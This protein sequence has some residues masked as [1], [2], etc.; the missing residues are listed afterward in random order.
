M[1]IEKQ[2]KLS[3]RGWVQLLP[4]EPKKVIRSA[5]FIMSVFILSIYC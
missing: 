4:R 2:I 5:Y 1:M 3:I